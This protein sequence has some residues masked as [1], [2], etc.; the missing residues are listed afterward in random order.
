MP[1]PQ[2]KLTPVKFNFI[3]AL[4]SETPFK[5]G[6]LDMTTTSLSKPMARV[7]D[8]ASSIYITRGHN[9]M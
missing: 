7:S 8:I 5:A 1:Y 9:L 2:P 6:T 3:L 4:D